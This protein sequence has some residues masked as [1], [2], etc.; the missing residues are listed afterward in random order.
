MIKLDGMRNGDKPSHASI[1]KHRLLQ[2][3]LRYDLAS[4]VAKAF[5]Q[6]AP[7]VPFAPNWHVEAIAW[8]LAEVKAGRIK[9]LLITLPPRSLKSIATSVAFPAWL[10]GHDPTRRIICVSYANELTV[11]HAN[12]CRI[13]MQ[14]NWYR[15][16]FALTRIHAQKNT[17]TEV[18]TTRHGFRLAT[19]VGGTLTGRGGNLIVIDDPIKASDAASETTRNK[20]NLWFD[21]TLLSRLDN[22]T[23]DA[24]VLVMQRLHV[25]DLAGHVLANGG[26]TH[27]DLP[28]VAEADATI[29]LGPDRVHR[30]RVG[31]LLHPAREPKAV[32]DQLKASMGASAFA[33]QYQQTPVPIGGNMIR[34]SWFQTYDEVPQ[35][36]RDD[37]IVQSWDT[38]SKATELSDYTVGITFHVQG[39]RIFIRDVVR[40]RLDYPN[41]VRRVL[42]ERSRWNP[43]A[44]LIEDKA[45]GTSLIQDLKANFV[46][47]IPILPEGDKIV[48]MSAQSAK[49]EG[50]AVHIPRSAEWLGD[51]RN[52]ILAFPHGQ[53]DDQVDALSQGLHWITRRR[54][55]ILDVL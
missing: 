43:T 37:K 5:A 12:D 11:K 19:T 30:R 20:V 55:T 54:P 2:A 36:G 42:A 15:E 29:R 23:D 51:F 32:L 27:L 10:L 46:P 17:E 52:E 33:A 31:D 18:R 44:L 45:S 50:G 14:S 48:R 8:H 7:G 53:F 13:V 28:A 39:E 35:R 49:I 38:A 41:L 26:W 34:W 4:F 47:V 40:E 16:L 25:D 3:L 6:V 9:R 24:I 21:E 22:K 1:D